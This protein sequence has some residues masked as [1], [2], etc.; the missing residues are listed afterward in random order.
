MSTENAKNKQAEIE[1]ASEKPGFIRRGL[2]SLSNTERRAV[3]AHPII[4]DA[5]TTAGVLVAAKFAAPVA[6]KAV[7][8]AR[9]LFGGAARKAGEE[10]SREVAAEGAKNFVGS[11]GKISKLFR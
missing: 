3:A 1:T 7:A 8:G 5:A 2:N 11:A 10:V 4:T 6:S 9:K